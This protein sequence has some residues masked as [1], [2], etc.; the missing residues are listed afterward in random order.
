MFKWYVGC[1]YSEEDVESLNASWRFTRL[2]SEVIVPRYAVRGQQYTSTFGTYYSSDSSP[3]EQVEI[4]KVMV[5]TMLA[6]IQHVT[7]FG[8]GVSVAYPSRAAAAK[9]Y[10]DM[11]Q[12]VYNWDNVVRRSPNIRHKR[13]P[14][15]DFELMYEYME[16]LEGY[17]DYHFS[18]E[19]RAYEL[20]R[21]TRSRFFNV[22]ASYGGVSPHA[23]RAAATAPVIDSMLSARRERVESGAGLAKPTTELILPSTNR[24]SSG[25][26]DSEGLLSAIDS[27]RK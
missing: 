16:E 12:H 6:P 15:E 19:Q 18:S 20:N 26:L 23:A 4:S 14:V 1:G 8:E 10:M 7:L 5:P 27:L 24:A 9:V 25:T 22:A 3:E 11:Q 2:K 17:R 21:K 13:P